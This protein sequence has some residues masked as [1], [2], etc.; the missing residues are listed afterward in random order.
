MHSRQKGHVKEAPRQECACIFGHC[1]GTSMDVQSQVI[2]AV[3][4]SGARVQLGK[5]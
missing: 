1:D 5:R 3:A 4:Q 2:L